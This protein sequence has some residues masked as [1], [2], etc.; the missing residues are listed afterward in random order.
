A[1]TAHRFALRVLGKGRW[2]TDPYDDRRWLDAAPGPL[3]AWTKARALPSPTSRSFR[4]W[5][6][7]RPRNVGGGS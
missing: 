1:A 7:A 6:A 5:W 2:G 3:R 4:E